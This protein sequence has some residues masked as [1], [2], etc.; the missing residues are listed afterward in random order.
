[1]PRS[2]PVEGNMDEYVTGK[3]GYATLIT[4][5]DTRN[6]EANSHI[7]GVHLQVI[8]PFQVVQ[9]VDAS[10]QNDNALENVKDIDHIN[11]NDDDDIKPKQEDLGLGYDGKT[12]LKY[13]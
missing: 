9:A 4:L 3:N 6:V 10:R 1:M 13:S 8:V 12:Q 7:I 2:R 5:H 11:D